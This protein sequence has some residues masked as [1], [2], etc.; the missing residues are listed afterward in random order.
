VQLAK[1]RG[2]TPTSSSAAQRII[3]IGMLMPLTSYCGTDD[4]PD[5]LSETAVR[6]LVYG[7]VHSGSK[8]SRSLR[9]S[10]RRYRHRR[11]PTRRPTQPRAQRWHQPTG[12]SIGAVRDEPIDVGG[13]TPAP[14]RRR[15]P[16]GDLRSS[17]GLP[18]SRAESVPTMATLPWWPR[19]SSIRLRAG[20]TRRATASRWCWWNDR[21]PTPIEVI[22]HQAPTIRPSAAASRPAARRTGSPP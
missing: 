22:R 9:R 20:T 14:T 17:L 4:L 5:D 11:P 7:P 10:H 19:R 18:C 8:G 15:R 21:R 12:R 3:S 16:H 2:G 1:R 6:P 13:T